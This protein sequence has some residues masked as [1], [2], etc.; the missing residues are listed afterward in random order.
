MDDSPSAIP[1]RM[2]AATLRSVAN[3]DQAY[4]LDVDETGLVTIH[5]L[6]E[7]G[8]FYG[9]MTLLQLLEAGRDEAGTI[10][11][12]LVTIRDWPAMEERGVWNHSFPEEWIPWMSSMKLNYSNMWTVTLQK[13]E[14]G[15]RNRATIETDLMKR[16]SLRGFRYIPQIL[17][18]NFL[19]RYGLF[20]A[21][22]ELA[23]I[24]PD[25][26][27]GRYF[28]HKKGSMNR[29]PYAGH[30][31]MVEILRDWMLDLAEQ[32]STEVVCWLTERPAEDGR[33]ETRD[34][35]QFVLEGR[36]FVQ[37]WDQAREQYPELEIRLFLSTTETVRN[38][39]VI[40]E[41]PENVKIVR[42]CAVP[43]E[44]VTRLPRDLY[45]NPLLDSYAAEGRWVGSYD[46]PLNANGKVETPEFKLP[47]RSPHRIRFF[48][49]NLLD[50]GYRSASGMMA[51]SNHS[52]EICS[53]NIAALAEWSWNPEGRDEIAFA[54]AWARKN[55]LDPDAVADWTRI[56][57]PIEWD[58]YDSG[59]P[60]KYAWDE[61]RKFIEE[62]KW[63]YLGEGL[64]RYYTT[65]ESFD[66]KLA[67]VR[68]A[69]EIAERI[70]DPSFKNETRIIET[71]ILMDQA[72]LKIAR[73][74]ALGG[75]EDLERQS[76]MREHLREL[77]EACEQNVLA[78]EAWRT[79]YGEGEWH[80]RVHDAIAATKRVAEDVTDLVRHRYLY[81]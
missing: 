69:K 9:G 49:Q 31:L 57:G 75:L 11:L 63:P 78:I 58:V 80:N 40:H 76:E 17:H 22:P 68:E 1:G 60:E 67:S 66:E 65:P 72:L 48:V 43:L 12:P 50:R 28:A 10:R 4:A 24:G 37:A 44:R 55:G 7:P 16:A 71:Y 3:R 15:V 41:A 5:A 64:F 2:Q 19:D 36:A 25:A 45:A 33:V 51:W 56:M 74:V 79:A 21:Y 73:S 13:F 54:R 42:A 53:M 8:L 35:G 27:A 29:V 70:P 26:L 14:R 47:H 59:F 20:S 52:R 61:A 81:D 6:S 39:R 38:Y 62:E 34:A 18:L 46:V 77:G 32:G 23:G 30:P